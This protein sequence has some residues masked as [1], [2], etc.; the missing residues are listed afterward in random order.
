MTQRSCFY[1]EFTARPLGAIGIT[2]PFAR[3]VPADTF[4]QAVDRLYDTH[5]HV[6]IKHW[7]HWLAGRQVDGTAFRTS[8]DGD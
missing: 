8:E 7:V 2:E 5:E 4:G 6:S 1:I 3:N